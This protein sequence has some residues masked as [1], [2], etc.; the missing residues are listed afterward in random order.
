MRFRK[1]RVPIIGTL[2]FTRKTQVMLACAACVMFVA[3]AMMANADFFSSESAAYDN[4]ALQFS[5][6][7]SSPCGLAWDGEHLWLADDGTDT[8]YKVSAANGSVLQSFSAPGSDPR[9]LAWDGQSLW[10]SDNAT[11]RIYKL[12]SRDGTVLLSLDAPDLPGAEV[13][14]ELGGLTWDGENLWCGTVAGWSSKMNEV[15]PLDGTFKRSYFTKGYPRAL[16]TD[17][18]FIWNATDNGGMRL[19][20]VYKY[21]LSDGLYVSDF[22]TPGFYPAG[23]TFDGQHLW[24]VDKETKTVYRLAAAEK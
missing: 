17:G 1:L 13:L 18:T 9:G 23:L 4:D 5:S 8:I 10:T 22:D 16:A 14:P 6:P 21:K 3:T 11:H 15:D 7:G 19:G 2:P 12:D 20:L 24:C